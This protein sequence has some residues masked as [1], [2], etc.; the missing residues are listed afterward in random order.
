MTV[1]APNYT[2]TPNVVY[3]AL[4][5]MAEAE[6]RV[7][8]TICRETFG[9]HQRSA[10]LSLTDLE[11]LTG[12]SRQGV[13]NG[14]EAG[15]ERGL[16]GRSAEGNGFVYFIIVAADPALASQPSGLVNEV[17]QS[18]SLTRGSQR[19]RPK[20]VNEVDQHVKG[21]KEK[22]KL[23]KPPPGGA[24][25]A[26][27]DG[28]GLSHS[29]ES[30]EYLRKTVGV[31]SPKQRHQLAAAFSAEILRCHWEHWQ[32]TNPQGRVGAFVLELA[33]LPPGTLPP[34]PPAT[35]TAQTGAP[36]PAAEPP[37]PW[38]VG[39]IPD[40]ETCPAQARR[41]LAS[42]QFDPD[43]RRIIAATEQVTTLLHQRYSYLLKPIYDHLGGPP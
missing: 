10:K 5:L 38:L 17:D 3:D 32:R 40:W 8:L 39:L 25:D 41:W 14:I 13:L 18:T 23:K 43:Q 7:T 33:S 37:P 22:R 6:M 24:A 27:G 16:I 20:V 19:S 11:Q 15:M 36:P 34:E 26:A 30:L 1:P 9:W 4:P 35:A 31:R 2:Q 42:A 21:V 12:L 29:S 28:G